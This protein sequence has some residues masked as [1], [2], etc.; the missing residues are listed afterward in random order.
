MREI[1]RLNEILTDTRCRATLAKKKIM[2]ILS[3]SKHE[4]FARKVA[5]GRSNG[6]AYRAVYGKKGTDANAHRLS[7]YEKVSERIKEL[8]GKAESKTLL[9]ITERREFLAS[10]VRSKVGEIDEKSPLAQSVEYTSKGKKIRLPDKIK[11]LELDAKMAGEL[12]EKKESSLLVPGSLEA[13]I[14]SLVQG[15]EQAST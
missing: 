7:R 2:P 1:G 6:A 8:K 9:T 14:V 12:I 5:E 11:A 4:A 3:N 13:A 15:N 10:V